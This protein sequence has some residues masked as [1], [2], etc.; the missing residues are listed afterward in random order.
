MADGHRHETTVI[1]EDAKYKT[2]QE[3]VVMSQDRERAMESRRDRD[4]TRLNIYTKQQME[5]TVGTA[6]AV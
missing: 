1:K 6:V 5:L 3:C 4:G 2:S